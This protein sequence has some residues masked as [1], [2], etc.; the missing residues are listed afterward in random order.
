M[1]FKEDFFLLFVQFW[2]LLAG[3]FKMLT[4]LYHHDHGYQNIR[5]ICSLAGMRVD[6]KVF[7][8]N[9]ALVRS[10]R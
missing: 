10:G 4:A 8:I 5:H 7:F 6:Q 1:P 3:F 9:Y 2:K